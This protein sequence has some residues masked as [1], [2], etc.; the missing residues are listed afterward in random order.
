MLQINRFSEALEQSYV[1]REPSVISEYV[2][3]LAQKFSS[4]YAE[5]PINGEEDRD[6]RLSRLKLCKIIKKILT[7]CLDLLGIEAPNKMLR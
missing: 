4:F 3:V 2:H 1:M 7:Q 6:L 5:L